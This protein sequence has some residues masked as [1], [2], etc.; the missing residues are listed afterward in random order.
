[1]TTASGRRLPES[2]RGPAFLVA[3]KTLLLA[4]FGCAAGGAIGLV[5]RPWSLR[6]R[7]TRVADLQVEAPCSMV[8]DAGEPALHLPFVLDPSASL[9]NPLIEEGRTTMR[10]LLLGFVPG[11]REGSAIEVFGLNSGS[12]EL[13][14]TEFWKGEEPFALPP[15]GHEVLAAYGTL[16]FR[17]RDAGTLVDLGSMTWK[18]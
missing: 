16:F 3:L 15:I 18:E 7:A 13:Y 17:A 6:A 4:M 5:V 8:F 11:I 1:M 10:F 9:M 2:G 14:W 12:E